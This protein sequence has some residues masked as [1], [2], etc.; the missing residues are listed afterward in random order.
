MAS[1]RKQKMAAEMARLQKGIR[2]KNVLVLHGIDNK[3]EDSWYL[4]IA[5]QLEKEG[6][7]SWVPQLPDTSRPNTQKNIEFIKANK[8]FPID[9][10]TVIIGHSSGAVLALYLIQSLPADII[11]NSVYLIASFREDLHF[12]G[13]YHKELFL[14]PFNFEAMK[15]HCGKFVFIHADDDPYCP[16]DQAQYLMEQTGGELIILP[17]QKHFSTSTAGPQYKEFPKLLEIINERV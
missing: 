10:E 7:K 11:I 2:M 5:A 8:D 12:E 4:W 1:W 9:R 6:Y 16:L 3:P 15:K 13:V 14:E 17:G